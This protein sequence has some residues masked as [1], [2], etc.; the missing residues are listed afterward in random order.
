MLTWIKDDS[1]TPRKA[2]TE[3]AVLMAYRSKPRPTKQRL[4]LLNGLKVIDDRAHVL[5]RED[6]FR[7]VRMAGGKAFRQRLGKAFDLVFAGE[8][9]E[10]RRGAMRA[11]AS[12]ADGVAS[13][14]VRRQQRF[15]AGCGRGAFFCQNRHCEQG[16]EIVRD[17]PAH[18]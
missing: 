3:E 2:R 14:T 1:E 8:R 18:G 15:A 9:S 13:R 4:L 10:G 5:R 6:E 16:D 7:H 12:A 17:L 11:V